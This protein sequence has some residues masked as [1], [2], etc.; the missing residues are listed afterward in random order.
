MDMYDIESKFVVHALGHNVVAIHHIGST[1]I[2]GIYAKPIIDM[3]IEVVDINDVDAH[4]AAMEE[5]GYEAMGEYSIAGRR[6][7]RKHDHTGTRTHHTHVFATGSPNLERHLEFRDFL[8]E[9][10]DWARKYSDLKR[11]L[12][13]AFP[14]DIEQYMDG[15]DAFIKEIERLA[16]IWRE[17]C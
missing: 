8:I 17:G 4:N 11:K 16:R 7:F 5:I 13:V 6:Y 9:H 3:L 12:A 1:A 10:A 14:D 15:K 2:P